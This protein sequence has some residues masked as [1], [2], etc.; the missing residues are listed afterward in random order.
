MQKMKSILILSLL[1][2]SLTGCGQSNNLT[3]PENS[4]IETRFQTPSGYTREITQTNSF[5]S[6]LKKL[7]LKPDKSTV[8]Y[9][10]GEEKRGDNI[11]LAV[12]DMDIGTKDLQQC[13]DAVMRLRGEYLFDQKKYA[14]IHFNF[15]HDGKARYFKDF[16]KG[17]YSYQKFRKYMEFV[18]ASANTA[19]LL[20]ELQPVKFQ[21]MKV[22]DVFIQKG[23]PYGHAV[24]V[25]DMAKNK[26]GEKVY[27]LA[28]SYMPAQE[29]QILVNRKNDEISPWYELKGETI[30]TPEWTF[31]STE[32]KR[33]RSE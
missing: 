18:F 3:K 24:I 11:Y 7:K 21:E 5:G 17:D 19:S 13:A 14:Q 2:Y 28:Q 23:N 1:C 4:T 29:T 33:F 26:S 27:M 6:Y 8:K 25:V 22:G 30:Y 20:K 15:L 31:K 10:N 32:L 9:F 12:V 16:A